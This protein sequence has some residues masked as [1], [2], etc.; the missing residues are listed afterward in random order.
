MS[1]EIRRKYGFNKLRKTPFSTFRFI[2][3]NELVLEAKER[4]LMDKKDI[5]TIIVQPI[6]DIILID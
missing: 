3:H 2:D 5:Q 6:P 1:K 4:L